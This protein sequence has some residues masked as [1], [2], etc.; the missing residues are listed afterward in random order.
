MIWLIAGLFAVAVICLTARFWLYKKIKANFLIG[1]II[2]NCPNP[3]IIYDFS[4]FKGEGIIGV[5]IGT[6]EQKNV[7]SWSVYM[8]LKEKGYSEELIEE[9]LESIEDGMEIFYVKDAVIP[10]NRLKKQYEKW[11]GDLHV[12][13]C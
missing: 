1:Q 4:K 9:A 6:Q 3:F 12:W 13:D 2:Y 7:I 11:K 10:Y 8:N 5:Q